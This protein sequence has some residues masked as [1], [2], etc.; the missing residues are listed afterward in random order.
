MKL[1]RIAVAAT[2]FALP[3]TTVLAQTTYGERHHIN[4]RKENQ[5]DRIAQGVNSGQ[6]TA[7]ET[8]HLER[9]EA[10]INREETRMRAHDDGRLTARDRHVLARQQNRE[11]AAIARDKHNDAH[12]PGAPT[13]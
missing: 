13:L 3:M 1:F 5:Q 9:N 12:Q 11:S 6:L 2:L 10:R 7:R 8:A 4:A